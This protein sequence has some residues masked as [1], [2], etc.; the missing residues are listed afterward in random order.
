MLAPA[1]PRQ[2]DPYAIDTYGSEADDAVPWG[3]IAVRTVTKSLLALC[4]GA[5]LGGTAM[6]G[7]FEDA[8]AAYDRGD[9]TEALKGYRVLAAEGDARALNTIGYMY[10]HGQGVAKDS[11]EALK[12]YR[13]AAAQG[14]AGA[15]YIIGTMYLDGV[16]TSQ[17]SVQA[18]KF[19]SLSLVRLKTREAQVATT[20][21]RDFAASTLSPAKLA[22][23]QK[24]VR[25]WK[26]SGALRGKPTKEQ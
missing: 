9:Y 17:D 20:E 10:N 22:E 26:P 3:G 8:Q 23:A 12:W 19:L 13:P 1:K 5:A 4:L 6:A 2:L 11:V 15:L 24:L 25:E 7:P 21:V 18:Y 14:N 16:G